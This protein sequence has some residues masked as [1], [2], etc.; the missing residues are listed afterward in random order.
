M[1]E[2]DT[3]KHITPIKVT[4]DMTD[5]EAD[6]KGVLSF[7]FEMNRRLTEGRTKGKGGWHRF[8]YESTAHE[9]LQ[10]C[11]D[12]TYEHRW[13]DAANYLMFLHHLSKMEESCS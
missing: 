11:I 5:V 2:S 13:I 3:G 7:S 10:K 8:P 1:K 4:P 12:A 6:L 9:F